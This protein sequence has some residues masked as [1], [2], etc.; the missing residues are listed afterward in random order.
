MVEYCARPHPLESLEPPAAPACVQ[1]A[2]ASVC[3]DAPR[4]AGPLFARR[5]ALAQTRLSR[6]G[7][8]SI[9]C[10]R[11][12]ASIYTDR[13]RAAACGQSGAEICRSGA[14]V[15]LGAEVPAVEPAVAARR[16]R[17]CVSGRSAGRQTIAFSRPP[18]R[19]E[20]DRSASWRPSPRFAP[21]RRHLLTIV[22]SG[23]P[24]FEARP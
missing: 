14:I 8:A 21:A 2:P 15:G 11:R 16:F 7:R 13:R 3:S 12:R 18:A 22:G 20:G 9:T 24:R 4:N 5:Q 17:R 1:R 6:R 23:A 19:E 10:G